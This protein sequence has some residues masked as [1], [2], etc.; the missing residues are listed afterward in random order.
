VEVQV[1]NQYHEL[2]GWL[3]VPALLI[4]LLEIALSNTLFRKIP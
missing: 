2:A 1:F 4:F 3:I